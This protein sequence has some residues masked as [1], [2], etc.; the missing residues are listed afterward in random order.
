MSFS[1]FLQLQESNENLFITQ[2]YFL[3]GY[4][5]EMIIFFIQVRE[6]KTVLIGNLH[7]SKFRLFVMQYKFIVIS[8]KE[9]FDSHL[10]FCLNQPISRNRLY[11]NLIF[12]HNFNCTVVDICTLVHYTDTITITKNCTCSNIA[13][14]HFSFLL[15]KN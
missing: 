10:I 2:T 8:L 4:Q 5:H 15:E 1:R 12:T 14:L 11:R 9:P 7:H 13:A 3:K 6:I